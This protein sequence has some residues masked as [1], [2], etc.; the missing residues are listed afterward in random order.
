[1]EIYGKGASPDF[2]MSWNIKLIMVHVVSW[3]PHVP[4]RLLWLWHNFPKIVTKAQRETSSDMR[5]P[6]DNVQHKMTTETSSDV[7]K[8][9]RYILWGMPCCMLMGG[10]GMPGRGRGSPPPVPFLA[11]IYFEM[12]TWS[13]HNQTS[14]TMMEGPRWIGQLVVG[15]GR[16]A[17]GGPP[18]SRAPLRSLTVF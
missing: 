12:L 3:G 5:S 7:I 18:R 13:M 8:S 16:W 2:F 6:R 14:K 17:Q 15:S 10:R 9:A 4:C 11:R 1:M